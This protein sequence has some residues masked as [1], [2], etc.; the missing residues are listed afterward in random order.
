MSKIRRCGPPLP[1][2]R[3]FDFSTCSSPAAA[4]VFDFSVPPPNLRPLLILRF[5]FPHPPM[6]N[7][8]WRLLAA[9]NHDWRPF[10]APLFFPANRP[11]PQVSNL[12]SQVSSPLTPLRR[13]PNALNLCRRAAPLQHRNQ[14]HLAPVLLHDGARGWVA[15]HSKAALMGAFHRVSSRFLVWSVFL[16]VPT[17]VIGRSIHPARSG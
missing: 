15:A 13:F 6:S 3:R 4:G 10:A 5:H 14:Q 2:G 1:L 7:T 16:D 11:A 8:D 17:S 12:K 9:K